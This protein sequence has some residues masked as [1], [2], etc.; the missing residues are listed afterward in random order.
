MH[1]V[2]LLIVALGVLVLVVRRYKVFNSFSPITLW[3]LVALAALVIALVGGKV[4]ALVGAIPVVWVWLARTL[5]AIRFANRLRGGNWGKNWSGFTKGFGGGAGK[6]SG[7]G[8]GSRTK[9]GKMPRGEA[10]EI[11]GLPATATKSDIDKAYHRLAKKL[12]PDTGGNE[13]HFRQ[14]QQAY[15]SLK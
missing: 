13:W 9:Q 10:L 3:G 12:H 6:G 2:L 14:L 15:E 7:K 1:L 5:N 8:A 11:L 4:L